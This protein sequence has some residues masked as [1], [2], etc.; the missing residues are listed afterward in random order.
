MTTDLKT[1]SL[2]ARIR[3]MFADVRLDREQMHTYQNEGLQFLKDNPFS[4]LFIDMGLGK[5]VIC[6]T[7]IADLLAEF[8]NDDKILVVGPLR[9]ATQTWPD[10]FR[11]WRHLAHIEPT[12]IHIDDDDPGIAVARSAGRALGRASSNALFTSERTKDAEKA[13]N[14]AV[15]RWKE[16]RRGELAT[17][18]SSVH[19]ISRDWLEWLVMFYKDRPWPYRTVIIDESSGFKDHR[20]TRYQCLQAVREDK[21]N[22]IT[23]LHLLTAT[24]AAETYEHLFAQLYLLDLGQRLGRSITGFRRSYMV[25]NK[26]AR[27]WEL[28]PGAEDSILAKIADICLVMK[29]QD[30]LPREEPLFVERTVTMTEAQHALYTKLEADAVVTLDDGTEVVAESAAALSAKLLQM[31]SGVLYDTKMVAGLEEEDDHVKVLKVHKIHDHKIDMLKQIVEES[32]GRPILVA[33]HFKSSKDRIRAAFKD[34]TFMDRDG[35]CVK[36]WNSGKIPMLAMHPASGGHGLNLQA[37]GHIIVWFDITWSLELFLQ[38]NGRLSRQG[39]KHRVTVF[40]L[41]CRDTLDSVVVGALRSKEDAQNKLFRI[42]KRM[43]ARLR[44]LL[45]G[46]KTIPADQWDEVVEILGNY[47]DA[48]REVVYDDDL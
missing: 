2:L 46:R 41:V 31:A 34:V 30:Y 19:I 33:Y 20:T 27:K 11:N 23:R 45:K 32:L 17:S 5:T 37:G 14:A 22:L 44:K 25:E 7:L 9:V 36:K 35:K 40:L 48:Q 12:V 10:E 18:K 47:E 16:A 26:Y 3:Q 21:R 6:E 28:R 39:Q 13:A 24:P 8:D 38:Y 15:A 4:A 43:K 42:L 1:S 29:E